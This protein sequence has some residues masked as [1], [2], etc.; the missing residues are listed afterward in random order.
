MR[1]L[2]LLFPLLTF[3]AV[4]ALAATDIGAAVRAMARAVGRGTG[5]A[6]VADVITADRVVKRAAPIMVRTRRSENP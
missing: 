1:R 5:L 6:A 4:P 2:C 3:A